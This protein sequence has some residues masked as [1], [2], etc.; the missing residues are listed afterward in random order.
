M[1]QTTSRVRR[2]GTLRESAWRRQVSGHE[3]THAVKSQKFFRLQPPY[4]SHQSPNACVILS[5]APAKFFPALESLARSRRAC[6]EVTAEGIQ[7]K[8][9]WLSGFREFSR[10]CRS[11]TLRA[12]RSLNPHPDTKTKETSCDRCE[13][14]SNFLGRALTLVV[15]GGPFVLLSK[16]FAKVKSIV[17][18]AETALCRAH[19]LF[20]TGACI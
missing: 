6:P 19:C 20:C 17:V 10:E 1:K 8:H 3:F 5:G 14:S 9:P 2:R 11:R 16:L 7:S 15:F 12:F 18:P 4:L 13:F